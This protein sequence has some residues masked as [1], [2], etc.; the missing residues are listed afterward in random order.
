MFLSR[1]GR[2]YPRSESSERRRKDT[3]AE[4]DRWCVASECLEAFRQLERVGGI[5][6]IAEKGDWC[7]ATFR[8]TFPGNTALGE[9]Y[10]SPLPSSSSSSSSSFCTYI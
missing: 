2:S 8:S 3:V 6:G 5:I 4:K 1:P 7:E 9:M 10:S